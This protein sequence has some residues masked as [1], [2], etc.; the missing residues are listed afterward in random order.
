V[1]CKLPIFGN[2]THEHHILFPMDKTLALTWFHGSNA[3]FP[4]HWGARRHHV[5]Q[6]HPAQLLLFGLGV[7]LVQDLLE[8]EALVAAEALQVEEGVA[9]QPQEGLHLQQWAQ[10]GHLLQTIHP[11]IPLLNFQ[12]HLYFV[13]HHCLHCVPNRL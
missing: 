6:D 10:D 2:L 9:L 12:M 8:V 5:I 13:H 4:E 3:G 11:G 7:L 1:G